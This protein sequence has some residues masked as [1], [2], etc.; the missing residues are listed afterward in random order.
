MKKICGAVTALIIAV[1]CFVSCS[2]NSPSSEESS[3]GISR[4]SSAPIEQEIIGTWEIDVNGYRFQEDRK[5]SL[6][7]DFSGSIHFDKD[8]KPVTEGIEYADEDMS[9][10]GKTLKISHKY[11]EFDEVLDIMTLERTGAEDKSTLD[12]EYNFVSGAY[13]KYIA[14][15]LGTEAEKINVTADIEGEKI[16]ITV[17]D[18]CNYETRNNTLEM[19]SENMDYIDETAT[20]VK[21]SYE[22]EG[23][24]ITLTY[25][26][27][28]ANGSASSDAQESLKEVLTRV[29]E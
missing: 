8:K 12:G 23:D 4:I 17:L 2:S 13:L 27:D 3:S 9:F 21:Y 18:Y 20:S 25:I 1:S 29:K 6:I 7:M 28:A 16:W 11:E 15:G 22:I 5:V 14:E 26:E 24:T 10:D 19:F